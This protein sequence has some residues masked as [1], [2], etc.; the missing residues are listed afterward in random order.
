MI[1]DSPA[2]PPL[3]L[4]RGDLARRLLTGSPELTDGGAGERVRASER[5]MGAV[6]RAGL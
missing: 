5:E 2:G 4:I 3:L 6:N 1:I